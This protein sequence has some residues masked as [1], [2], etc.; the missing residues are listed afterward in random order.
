[1]TVT[2]AGVTSPIS[3]YK[4]CVAE[5]SGPF[6]EWRLTTNTTPDTL[7]ASTDHEPHTYKFYCVAF[8]PVGNSGAD[9]PPTPDL[10]FNS[11]VGVDT[12]AV[13]WTLALEGARP[14]PSLDGEPHVWFTLPDRERAT[15]ELIDV[16]GRRVARREVG[17]LG[18]GPHM[19][20]L[21][22]KPHLR[23]GI[24]FLRLT[25]GSQVLH[26]RLVLMR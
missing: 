26:T 23:S 10:T 24:Y 20:T 2:W 19:A 21:A 11:V 17:T 12:T 5:D 7:G 9:P 22:T 4:V 16:A 13:H 14:N 18:A 25:H 1:M 3:R 8:D 6:K 15:L